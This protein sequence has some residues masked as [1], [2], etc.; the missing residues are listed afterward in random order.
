MTAALLIVLILSIA[1]LAGSFLGDR[2]ARRYIPSPDNAGQGEAEDAV[3]AEFE[4][5]RR[6][7]ERRKRGPHPE[8]PASSPHPEATKLSPHPEVRTQSASKDDGGRPS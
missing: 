8:A 3:L 5:C 7:Y 1:A 6:A 2:W 4:R